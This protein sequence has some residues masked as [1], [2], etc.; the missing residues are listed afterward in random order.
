LISSIVQ[1]FD[2]HAGAPGPSEDGD[3]SIDPMRVVPF[4]LLHVACLAVFVVGVSPFAVGVFLVSY[5]IR[6]FGI[7]GGYH[8]YFSHR[9]YKMGRVAQF[10]VA[11]LGAAATQRGPLWWAAHHRHHHRHSDEALDAHSPVAHSFLWSH[12]GWVLARGNFR[13]RLELIKDFARFPELHFIDRFDIVVPVLYA[14]AMFALGAGAAALWP[15]AGTSGWQTLVWGYVLATVALYHVTFSI[16]SF[17]HLAWSG[18]R[19]YETSDESR[20]VWWL[21]LPTFGE[22][23]HNNHHHFPASARLGFFWWE[24]DVGYAVL[25]VLEKLGIVRDLRLVPEKVLHGGRRGA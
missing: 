11:C 21:A 1:W 5:A 24:V 10:V 13:T 22:S 8:R 2:S 15:E 6:T 17:T 16:N 23:W 14:V 12:V 25:R 18:S 4:V 19:R 20:N 3:R 9:A 7:T